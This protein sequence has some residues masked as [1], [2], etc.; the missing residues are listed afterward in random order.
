ML[1]AVAALLFLAEIGK[2]IARVVGKLVDVAGVE[3][4]AVAEVFFQLLGAG[5]QQDGVMPFGHG[6][7]GYVHGEN[8]GRLL[9]DVGMAAAALLVVVV[10]EVGKYQALHESADGADGVADIRKGR[11]E[12]PGGEPNR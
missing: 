9:F 12:R 2:G 10:G 7:F 8:H 11:A 1:V 6:L 5:A 3:G 4:F